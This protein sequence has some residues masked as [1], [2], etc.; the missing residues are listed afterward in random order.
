MNNIFLWIAIAIFAI[1]FF[2][3]QLIQLI[4]NIMEM[5]K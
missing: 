3:N 4:E 1:V 5:L 2:L